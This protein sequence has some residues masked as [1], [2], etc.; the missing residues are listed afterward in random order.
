MLSI[1]DL[2]NEQELSSLE[3]GK[4]AGGN[5][6]EIFWNAIAASGAGSDSGSGMGAIAL[7]PLT[8]EE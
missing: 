8:P 3:I 6:R 5:I 1:T 7:P 4:V 2:H